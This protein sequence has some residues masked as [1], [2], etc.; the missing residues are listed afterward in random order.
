M[1][2]V[3]LYIRVPKRFLLEKVLEF[4]VVMKKTD[5]KTSRI[6]VSVVLS[7]GLLSGL[8]LPLQASAQPAVV[9]G[10]PDFT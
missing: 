2:F 9:K 3:A 6:M 10:L 7:L 8:A 5:V 1:A 4:I